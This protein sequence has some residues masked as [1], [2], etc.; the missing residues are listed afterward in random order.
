LAR[1]ISILVHGPSKVGK[2]TL[3]ATT[4]TPRLFID[5]ESGHRFLD[6]GRLVIWKPLEEDPPVA[7][8]TWDTCVVNAKDW[9]TMLKI[10]E[11]LKYGRHGFKSVI[12]D[13]LS[14]LQQQCLEAIA[15]RNQMQ[16]QQWGQLLRD[17]AGMMRDLRDLTEHPTNPLQAVVLTAM[18]GD[19]SGKMKPYLQG[20]SGTIAPYYYD[21]CGYL[22]QEEYPHPDPTQGRYKVRRMYIEESDKWLA[23]ERV[24]GKLGAVVEQSE[25]NVCTMLDKIFGPEETNLKEKVSNA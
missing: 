20:R 11:C 23:G 7:D 10:Y 18:T 4:P 1:A 9:A 6:L 16:T 22:V 12:I 13:S 24:R 19:V 25:L 3:A 21:L 5:C 15:G 8:G 2:S 17:F 14:E